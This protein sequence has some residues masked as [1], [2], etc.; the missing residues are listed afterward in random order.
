MVT[1]PRRVK[2]LFIL[3]QNVLTTRWRHDVMG[4]SDL[5]LHV[6][7][8]ATGP[9]A[10][11]AR[12][13]HRQAPHRPGPASNPPGGDNAAPF[14]WRADAAGAGA[15]EPQ[16]WRLDRVVCVVAATGAWRLQC[17]AGPNA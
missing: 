16:K 9:A 8:G 10:I 15:G 4:S 13:P 12:C 17:A 14:H 2:A 1:P 6:L 5:S 7:P 11:R 3:S